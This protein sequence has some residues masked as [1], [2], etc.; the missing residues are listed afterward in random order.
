[1]RRM[2]TTGRRIWRLSLC[3]TEQ[4][5]AAIRTMAQQRDLSVAGL[6]LAMVLSDSN[7]NPINEDTS[8]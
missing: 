5:Q 6:I 8:K 1:M 2:P 4:E 3:V 7:T